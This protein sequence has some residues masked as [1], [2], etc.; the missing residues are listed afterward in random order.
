MMTPGV[1]TYYYGYN[2]YIADKNL[3]HL[4]T[5]N[6]LTYNMDYNSHGDQ[7]KVRVESSKPLNRKV[8]SP[9]ILY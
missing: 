5:G 7:T 1:G 4:L 8:D 6:G 3:V 2:D 9:V